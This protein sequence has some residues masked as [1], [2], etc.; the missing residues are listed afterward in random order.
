MVYSKSDVADN[1]IKKLPYLDSVTKELHFETTT[2]A[3]AHMLC[4]GAVPKYRLVHDWLSIISWI[5]KRH[6]F[7]TAIVIVMSCSVK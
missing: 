6:T 4:D 2:L 7:E 5:A 1:S 3:N